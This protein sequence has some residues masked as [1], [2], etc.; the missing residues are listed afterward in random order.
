VTAD[1]S[2]DESDGAWDGTCGGES[3]ETWASLR[4]GVLGETNLT[5]V[6]RPSSPTQRRSHEHRDQ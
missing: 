6:D 4:G 3:G 5:E 2:D 1:G